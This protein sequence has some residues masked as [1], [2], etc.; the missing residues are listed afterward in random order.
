[1]NKRMLALVIGI[2]LS[3]VIMGIVLLTLALSQN[4]DW[5]PT[6]KNSLSKTS[7]QSQQP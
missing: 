1:M 6:P 5:L 2:P 7:W 3:S 4:S